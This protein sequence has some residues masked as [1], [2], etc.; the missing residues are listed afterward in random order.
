MT[1]DEQAL[2]AAIVAHPEEDTPRLAYADWLDE[3][4]RPERAEYI[5]IQIELA[6]LDDEQPDTNERY[7]RLQ[8]RE[9]ELAKKYHPAWAKAEAGITPDR[10]T[11]V[12]FNRGFIHEVWCSV[13]YFIDHGERFLR[14]VPVEMVV[15]RRAVAANVRKLA[16]T[17]HFTRLRGIKFFVQETS[18]EVA[19]A[20]LDGCPLSGVRSLEFSGFVVNN[21]P[22]VARARY[23]PVAEALAR[24]TQ[25]GGLGRLGLAT[26]G[27]GDDGGR[28]LAACTGLGSLR[29]L[30]L[31][32]NPMSA[33]VCDELRKRF[34]PALILGY[35]DRQL[36]RDQRT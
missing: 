20:F 19:V 6:R 31:M 18:A 34:G 13:K 30:D 8:A 16:R 25:L 35:A 11:H 32:H 28:A 22:P 24:S 15:L 2:L 14:A 9:E 26:A 21:Y 4:R 10:H 7:S 1:A 17:P 5:R 12:W 29:E 3:H 23:T 33:D 36:A 27:V